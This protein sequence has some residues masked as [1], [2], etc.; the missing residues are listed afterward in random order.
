MGEMNLVEEGLK[1]MVL[2]M[3]TVFTFLVLMIYVLKLQA[4]L[5]QKFFPQTN[6]PHKKREVAKDLDEEK[7]VVAAITGAVMAAKKG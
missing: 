6:I 4:F 1:F 2:G 7:R 3:G 5:I